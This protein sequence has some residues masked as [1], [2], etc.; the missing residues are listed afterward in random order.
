MNLLPFL[1]MKM[2]IRTCW[3]IDH[4]SVLCRLLFD[5]G[6]TPEVEEER[7]AF[8]PPPG[9]ESPLIVNR[10]PARTRLC[11]PYLAKPQKTPERQGGS[12]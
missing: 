2:C 5:G 12:I 1:L 7:Y 10:T 9:T 4:P 8:D 11:I 6:S 3:Q